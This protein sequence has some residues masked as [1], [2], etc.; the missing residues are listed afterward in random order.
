MRRAQTL[1]PALIFFGL[2]MKVY[3]SVVS[4]RSDVDFSRVGG[5]L[6]AP[7]D[8]APLFAALGFA[9]SAWARMEQQLDIVLIHINKE[10]HSSQLYQPEYPIAFERKVK[11]AKR[12]FNQHPP[13]KSY[14]DD[15]RLFTSKIKQ[16]APIRNYLIHSILQEWDDHKQVATMQVIKFEGKD[17]FR[18]QQRAVHLKT[19]KEFGAIANSANK[20]LSHVTRKVLTDAALR[21]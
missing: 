13:L 14:R 9:G 20:F 4:G 11:L 12:W 18:V 1:F 2:P 8:H 16:I 3:A 10:K 19:I 15:I 17:T 5:P 6:E 7:D 21:I